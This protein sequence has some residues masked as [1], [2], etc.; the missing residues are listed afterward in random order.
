MNIIKKIMSNRAQ[1]SMEVGILIAAAVLVAIIAGYLY[2]NNVKSG[3]EKAGKKTSEFI[4]T[5]SNKSEDYI[6][7]LKNLK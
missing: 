4:N 7:K 6:S 2:I 3:A 5:T 1:L